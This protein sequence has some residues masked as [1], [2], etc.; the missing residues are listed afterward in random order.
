MVAR[1]KL[2]LIVFLIL[3]CKEVPTTKYE[4][5][6][7]KVT[8]TVYNSTSRQTDGNPFISA[9]GDSLKPGMKCIAVSKDLYRLGLKKDTFVY[10][11]GLKG[12]YLVK[13]RMHDRWK[14]KIDIYMGNDI[15][16]A[17][18]WG[19]KKVNVHYRVKIDEK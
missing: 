18:R 3:G 11:E 2:I 9:F 5:K 13:D 1:Y 6:T 16:A 12:I 4:W 15:I 8:A 14:N 7:I 17:K 19:R 10:I